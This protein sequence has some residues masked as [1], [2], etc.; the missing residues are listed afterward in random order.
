MI[1]PIYAAIFGL[2]FIFLSIRVIKLR[3]NNH[4]ALGDDQL[5]ELTRA[6]RVHG[7]FAE[8][9]PFALLL[10][11]FLETQ[12]SHF[13][14]I[15]FLGLTLLAGRLIHAH[16]VS[17]ANEVIQLRKIGMVLSFTVIISSAIRILLSYF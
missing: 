17:Q 7:N 11:F 16:G 4:I 5:P 1:T 15:H 2:F 6:M 14:F 9:V 3:A 8:Y 10:M 12:T 13:L